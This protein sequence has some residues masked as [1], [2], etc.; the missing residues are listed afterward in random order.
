MQGIEGFEK[1]VEDLVGATGNY[2]GN[3]FVKVRL[4]GGGGCWG[5]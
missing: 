3:V 4:L 2:V 1:V 5:C